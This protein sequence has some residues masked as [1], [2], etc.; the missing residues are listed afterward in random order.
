MHRILLAL[1]ALAAISVEMS[2]SQQH[3]E[4]RDTW[5]NN[6][7]GCISYLD[8]HVGLGSTTSV[9]EQYSD[10]WSALDQDG[11]TS[12]LN[13]YGCG[14]FSN[15]WTGNVCGGRGWFKGQSGSDTS[16]TTCFQKLAPWVLLNG[17]RGGNAYYKATLARNDCYMGYKD[18]DPEPSSIGSTS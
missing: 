16:S 7:P 10:N 5:L 15:S 11:L 1:F 6:G 14:N 18:P 17:I 2:L 8:P 3:L 12:C 9:T 13:D 4:Q